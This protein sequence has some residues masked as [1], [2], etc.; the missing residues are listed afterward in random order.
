MN[1][2]TQAAEDILSKIERDPAEVRHWRQLLILC[3]DQKSIETLQTLQ[4]ILAAIE[5]IWNQR[6]QKAKDA[7]EEA[8]QKQRSTG[9]KEP[10]PSTTV[11]SVTLTV[12]QKETFIKLARAPQAPALLYRFGLFLEEDFDLP[13]SARTLYERAL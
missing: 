6:R 3:F 8:R 13:H 12:R 9:S 4:V 2:T 5:Q 11:H 10:L 7:Y 1:F